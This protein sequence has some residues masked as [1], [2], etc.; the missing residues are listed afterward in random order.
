M[1]ALQDAVH[2][3]LVYD[4]SGPIIWTVECVQLSFGSD[5]SQDCLVGIG[6][7]NKVGEGVSNSVFGVDF[8]EA[9]V[10]GHANKHNI[11]RT[12][13]GGGHI[14]RWTQI[15]VGEGSGDCEPIS[16]VIG[17]NGEVSDSED[18]GIRDGYKFS[19]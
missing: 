18:R 14:L 11:R 19:L 7:T 6:E 5:R 1:I 12:P 4:I 15:A 8:R 3:E 2:R 13:S 9:K 17:E 16:A 10:A